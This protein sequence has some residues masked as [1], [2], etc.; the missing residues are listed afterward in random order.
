MFQ[1]QRCLGALAIGL[2]ATFAGTRIGFAQSNHFTG[3]DLLNQC[4]FAERSLDDPDSL[5]RDGWISASLCGGFILGI[6]NVLNILGHDYKHGPPH[7]FAICLPPGGTPEQ[8]VN[9]VMKYLRDNPATTNESGAVLVMVA[10][11]I[12]FPCQ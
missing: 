1:L 12:A 7:R 6:A 9:V 3:N 2:V 10:L 11:K 8:L 4:R 5:D